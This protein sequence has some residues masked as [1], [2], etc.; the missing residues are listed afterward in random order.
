[1]STNSVIAIPQGDHWHGRFCH[2]DGNPQSL[3]PRLQT[4]V[5]RD[6]AEVAAELLTKQTWST[7]GPDQH[8]DSENSLGER[9][10]NVVGYGLA[11]ST[12]QEGSH[13]WIEADG[14]DWGAQWAYVIYPKHITVL[15]S[16]GDATWDVITSVPH[17]VD[18]TDEEYRVI[19]CG[20]NYETCVHYAWV[21]FPE[22][23]DTKYNTSEWLSLDVEPSL[24]KAVSIV[25][26]G[27]PVPFGG[28]GS[29]LFADGS[30]PNFRA[31]WPKG[32]PLYWFSSVAGRRDVRVGRSVKGGIKLE[33]P[34]ILAPNA[35]RDE[36]L[37]PAGT[38][39]QS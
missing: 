23:K 9:A 29:L 36:L 26:D 12:E 10:F 11:H 35:V 27:E 15:G 25:V 34:I 19:E 7:I 13:D 21:H 24:Y 30:R 37:V 33:H 20:A 17:E 5:R 3:L 6:S 2:W 8:L 39:V 32:R 18:L 14:D 31:G 28:S 4:I 1:M 22:A 16:T 38:V